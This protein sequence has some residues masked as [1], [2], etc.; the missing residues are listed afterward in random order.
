MEEKIV[1]SAREGRLLMTS[2]LRDAA[3]LV[4]G[5]CHRGFRVLSSFFGRDG[6][7][8]I[9]EKTEAPQRKEP[10]LHGALRG[11]YEAMEDAVRA[12]VKDALADSGMLV[13]GLDEQLRP[14]PDMKIAGM[15]ASLRAI[16]GFARNYIVNPALSAKSGVVMK[17]SDMV[18]KLRRSSKVLSS[19]ILASVYLGLD[20]LGKKT[21]VLLE[22]VGDA[23]LLAQIKA[24]EAAR[25]AYSR[26]SIRWTGY[27][28]IFGGLG[29]MGL[30]A[31][32][33]ESIAKALLA[34]ADHYN[35]NAMH[36]AGLDV[37]STVASPNAAQAIADNDTVGHIAVLA[38]DYIEK[39]AAA[40]SQTPQ[41][42]GLVHLSTANF[43][44]DSLINTQGSSPPNFAIDSLINQM[45]AANSGAASYVHHAHHL[46]HV[47]HISQ[48]ATQVAAP[49]D[50]QAGDADKL[51]D[52][53]LQRLGAGTSASTSAGPSVSPSAGAINTAPASPT[54]PLPSAPK[55]LYPVPDG[56]STIV[57]RGFTTQ[58]PP[59]PHVAAPNPQT[60]PPPLSGSALSTKHGP[61]WND[62]T[63][64]LT[65]DIH[66][67]SHAPSPHSH[68]VHSRAYAQTHHDSWDTIK[69]EAPDISWDT[70]TNRA[71][72][73]P[74]LVGGGTSNWDLLTNHTPNDWLSMVNAPSPKISLGDS[75]LWLSIYNKPGVDPITREIAGAAAALIANPPPPPSQEQILEFCGPFMGADYPR[76]W[77]CA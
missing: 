42:N 45:G 69:N 41:A 4:G 39:S 63:R 54:V 31:I 30:S 70:V 77:R 49:V 9:R 8:V 60:T 26:R 66:P 57:H 7:R 34:Y 58:D 2:E 55:T 46:H 74:D 29:L 28:I 53:E 1:P 35:N 5:L 13:F 12:G 25:R 3:P 52:E 44:V 65:P 72:D 36:L 68:G 24:T 48:A 19:A 15:R 11:Q 61:E 21:S 32:H 47:R 76:A 40:V 10:S 38:S 6:T 50:P 17:T 75:N 71:N 62:A 51:M 67:A 56:S 73:A 64:Y 59:I 33:P 16:T 27:G 20:N 43:G 22:K 37:A 23:G 18:Q 14:H